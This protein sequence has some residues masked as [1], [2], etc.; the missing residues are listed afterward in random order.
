VSADY[1]A[2][3]YLYEVEAMTALA[4]SRTGDARVIPVLLHACDWD[5]AAFEGLAPLPSDKRPVS[6]WPN[7]N[8]A[9]AAIVRGIREAIDGRAEATVV[10]LVPAYESAEI[11]GLAEQMEYAR[12]RRALLAKEGAS[13]AEIDEE[14][15]REISAD[16]GAVGVCRPGEGRTRVPLGLRRAQCEAAE[17]VRQGVSRA[18]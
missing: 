17:R 14:I 7:R 3:D 4:R 2:S 13:T 18:G 11:R 5:I 1:L 12:T 16:R 10:K 8:E 15:L 9:W 6:S